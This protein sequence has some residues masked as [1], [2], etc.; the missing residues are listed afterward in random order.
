M[1]DLIK[2]LDYEPLDLKHG[3]VVRLTRAIRKSSGKRYKF[4]GAIYDSEDESAP[5]YLDLIE[6]GRGQMRS[7]P[8]QHVIKDAAA[9]KELRSRIAAKQAA[10]NE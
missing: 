7:I 5:L 9:T 8:P 1:N 10:K 2:K 3:D 6:I 4:M